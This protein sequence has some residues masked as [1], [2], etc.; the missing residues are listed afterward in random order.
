M[1]FAASSARISIWR[2]QHPKRG[3]QFGSVQMATEEEVSA[4]IAEQFQSSLASTT[5][6]RSNQ[7][8]VALV[9]Y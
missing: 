9:V 6:V 8:L 3:H 1:V 5:V 4:A 7:A 2:R